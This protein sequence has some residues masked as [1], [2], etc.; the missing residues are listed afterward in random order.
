MYTYIQLCTCTHVCAHVHMYT[1]LIVHVAGLFVFLPGVGRGMRRRTWMLFCCQRES[2]NNLT[3]QELFYVC[4]QKTK[5]T[6]KKVSYQ[7]YLV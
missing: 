3:L 5:K 7:K 1:R 4:V 2:E 6:K